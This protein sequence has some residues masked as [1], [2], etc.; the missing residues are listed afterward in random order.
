MSLCQSK[1]L[2]HL[3]FHGRTLDLL[4]QFGNASGTLISPSPLSKK[5]TC[6]KINKITKWLVKIICG[7]GIQKIPL[8][9]RNTISLLVAL[10]LN[11]TIIGFVCLPLMARAH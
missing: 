2:C 11:G 9:V 5:Q 1:N 7:Q 4:E 8:A 6:I 10:S 3:E